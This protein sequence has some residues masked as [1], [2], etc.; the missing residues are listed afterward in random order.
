M[1]TGQLEGLFTLSLYFIHFNS[2]VVSGAPCHVVLKRFTVSFCDCWLIKIQV[3]V[4]GEY[5]STEY[6]SISKMVIY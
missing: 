4:F 5:V 6:T 1:H 3:Q 2:E